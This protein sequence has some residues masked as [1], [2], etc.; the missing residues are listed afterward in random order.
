MVYFKSISAAIALLALNLPT[1]QGQSV[2][3]ISDDRIRSLDI[4]PV[5]GR[6]YSIM[7]N[8]FHSTC[9]MVDETTTPSYN[10]DYSFY[11]FTSSTDYEKEL[12]GKL[13]ASFSYWGVKASIN[14]E[15]KSSTKVSTER[16]MVVASMRL[17]RYYSSLREEVSPLAEDARELLENEDYVGFF[18]ACG[19]NY[20]RGIRRAQEV[21]AIFSFYS[22][23]RET[24]RQFA[25]GLKVSGWGASVDVSFA[26]K[27]KF[28]QA[29][30]SLQI[31][32]KG[33]GM[34]LNQE[35]AGTLV[36]TSLDEY[37]EV[38]KFAFKSF[39]QNEDSP[40]IGMVYGIEV[41]PWVNNVA[42]QNAAK[43]H[44]SNI[45]LPL[46]QNLIQKSEGGAC[47]DQ[48]YFLD[49][50]GQ[51]CEFGQLYNQTA[52]EYNFADGEDSKTYTCRPLRTLDINLVKDNMST[53]GEFVARLD[54]ALRYRFNQLSTL[55]RCI[56]YV[57][58]IPDRFKYNI[59]K[60]NDNVKY[61]KNIEFK[62]S[63]EE[64]RRTIDPNG[65]YSL[66]KYVGQEIDEY[67]QMYYTPCLAALFGSN[68]G[69]TPDVDPQFFMA[70]PWYAHD[71]CM[72]LTCLSTN[73]RWNR[74]Q[75][76]CVSGFNLGSGAT[77]YVADTPTNLCARRYNEDTG[78]YDCKYDGD[79]LED[80]RVRM[81]TC[82]NAT[83]PPTGKTDVSYLV[84]HFCMP[85]ILGDKLSSADQTRLDGS[86]GAC[87]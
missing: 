67:I 55:E 3:T 8:A 85:V 4:T 57:N 58:S 73:T 80:Q 51:C 28:K 48:T 64:L 77:P 25:A 34:G 1:I 44:D 53:N 59:L 68:I 24:A 37:N 74:D 47:K 35:G 5:L 33:F 62:W 23:S 60:G 75:G 21:T 17:E 56:S 12:E 41:V 63:V 72:M 83:F 70:T 30:S 49:K 71:E 87:Q 86:L 6:G 69:T 32:I 27:S 82:Y 39:T 29:S 46:P 20:T 36:A 45:Q 50:F 61:D 84:D 15:A 7:T 38:M 13:S 26:S 19:P 43:L 9:L 78:T 79:D 76:G 40:N 2:Y 65:D 42:F 54:G 10:Y 31:T 18:K 14:A 11:D 52:N 66:I 16:H 81:T 22:S